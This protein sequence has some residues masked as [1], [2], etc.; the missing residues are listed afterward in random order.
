MPLAYL[1]LSLLRE[2]DA[3]FE[4]AVNTPPRGIGKRTLDALRKRARDA[5]S[6]L[7]AA[8]EAELAGGTLAARAKSALRAFIELIEKLAAATA[9][10][11]LAE[12]IERDR[13]RAAEALLRG[14]RQGPGRVAHRQPR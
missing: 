13:G 9:E 6:S 1:R 3:A 7:W 2:D 4:R 12:H 14:G 10:A 11:S 5:R 8:T